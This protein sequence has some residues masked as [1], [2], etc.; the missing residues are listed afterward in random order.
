MRLADRQIDAHEHP[1]SQLPADSLL[2]VGEL[3]AHQEGISGR[4]DKVVEEFDGPLAR[5]AHVALQRHRHGDLGTWLL[6]HLPLKLLVGGRIHVEINV[7]GID[8]L[9]GGKQRG[10][11]HDQVAAGLVGASDLA[12]DRRL[13]RAE[14][15]VQLVHFEAGIGGFHGGL[16]LFLLGHIG[17]ERLFADAGSISSLEQLGIALIIRLGQ[18]ELRLVQ[19]DLGIGLIVLGLVRSGIDLEEHVVFLDFRPLLGE[20]EGFLQETGD[21]RLD[22][23]RLNGPGASGI[24]HVVRHLALHRDADGEDR[25]FRAALRRRRLPAAV[26]RS[27]QPQAQ[28]DKEERT[29][30]HSGSRLA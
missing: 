11:L 24:L 10:I 1:R 25:Q 8:R 13:D 4:I 5:I 6:V 26:Y 23:L 2:G 3:A 27:W 18:L 30:A 22:F 7:H 15:E 17:V 29:V 9:D 28:E 16:G 14:I 19:A 21:A 20:G 12:V